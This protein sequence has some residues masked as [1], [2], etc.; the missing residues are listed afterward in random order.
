MCQNPLV[1]MKTAPKFIVCSTTAVLGRYK[2]CD[3]FS[4]DLLIEAK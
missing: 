2:P 3:L 4:T 1:L